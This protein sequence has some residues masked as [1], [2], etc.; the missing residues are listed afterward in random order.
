MRP[1]LV[2]L[3]SL[4]TAP[5][6]AQGV[7]VMRPPADGSARAGFGYALEAAVT[8]HS[9]STGV[10][11]RIG[12]PVIVRVR[13]GSPA[14]SAGLMAGDT[15]VAYDGEDI[16]RNRVLLAPPAGTQVTVRYRRGG[17]ERE[18]VL[19]STPVPRS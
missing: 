7:T 19:T 18:V 17:I 10:R 2:L 9:D 12:Y 4:L 15:L 16:T 11:Y 3:A 6:A 5:L 8:P 14:D 1:L 13:P